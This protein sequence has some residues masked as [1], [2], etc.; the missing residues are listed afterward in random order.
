MD[1]A[2]VIFG[3]QLFED[4]PAL[5]RY[6]KAEVIMIEA[7]NIFSRHNYHKHKLL[8]IMASMRNYASSLG[9]RKIVVNYVEYSKGNSFLNELQKIISVKKYSRLVWVRSADK[10]PNKLLNKV[11]DENGLDFEV[12]DSTMFITPYSELKEFFTSHDS[13]IMDNFYRWQRKRMNILMDGAKP[14]GGKWSYDDQNRK[15]LPKDKV[16]P[17]I[18]SL[19]NKG[20]EEVKRIIDKSFANNP[21]KCSEFWL[22]TNHDQATAWLD[23]FLEKRFADFGA[24]EDAMRKD[25]AFLFHSVISPLLNIGL[26]TPGEVIKKATKYWEGKKIPLNS[27]EG[28]VRQIIGWREYMYGM[29]EFNEEKIRKNFFGF[30]KKLESEWYSGPIRNLPA[31]VRS[32]MQTTFKYGYNH[33]IERLMVLGNWFLLNEYSPDSVYEWF[34]SMYVDAYEWVMVPNVYAMSQYADGGFLA[35]KPYISGGNY[36]QKMGKWWST[37]EE[38]KNSEFTKLYWSFIKKHSDKFKNNP[39]MSLAINQAKKL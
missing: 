3:N 2:V 15:A 25:E 38:A 29:Y 30:N 36:L 32:A 14:A 21:G 1:T 16:P 39:R 35:T 22:P 13:P 28:F 11:C 17:A 27:F 5:K 23:D 8:L 34:S 31:P 18:P 12:L 6:P 26:I 19:D 33:H 4:H 24:Y 7:D 10:N 20:L 37:S 9:K